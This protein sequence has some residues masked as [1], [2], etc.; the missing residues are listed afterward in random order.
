MVVLYSSR[1]GQSLDNMLG[2]NL[3][4]AVSVSFLDARCGRG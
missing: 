4:K 2:V 3:H 1:A